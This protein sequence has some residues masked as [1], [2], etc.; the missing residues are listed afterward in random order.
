MTVNLADRRYN[1]YWISIDGSIRH[2]LGVQL[3]DIGVLQQ[4]VGG[5]IERVGQL[6]EYEV[7]GLDPQVAKRGGAPANIVASAYCRAPIY[8]PAIVT[9][10]VR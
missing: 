2:E 7:T 6:M 9:M 1:I 10:R 4:F 5:P 3:P 8:G